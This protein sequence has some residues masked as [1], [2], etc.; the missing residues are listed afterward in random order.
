MELIMQPIFLTCGQACIAM[1]VGK[2][3]EEVIKDMKTDRATY[4]SADRNT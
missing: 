1:I 2:N 3:V 4:W